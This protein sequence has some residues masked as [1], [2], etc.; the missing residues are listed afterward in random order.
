M[1]I[2]HIFD[3][4]ELKYT[5]EASANKTLND[6]YGS[7]SSYTKLRNHGDANADNHVNVKDL[8]RTL[9]YLEDTTVE[10]ESYG[11][12]VYTDNDE[13][14]GTVTGTDT[15]YLRKYLVGSYKFN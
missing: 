14:L 1:D 6:L 7:N 8:V 10:I 5:D 12:D 2:Y 4:T 9:R 15:E 11:A 3:T 13:T